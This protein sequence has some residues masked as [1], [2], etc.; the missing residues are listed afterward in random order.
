MSTI[1]LKIKCERT[2]G[3]QGGSLRWIFH[4]VMLTC[5]LLVSGTPPYAIPDNIQKMSAAITG[6][7]VNELPALDYVRKCCVVV[8]NLNNMLAS[9]ILG[10]LDNWHQIFIE[11]TTR[12]KIKFQNLVIGLVANDDFKS[13]IASLCIFLENET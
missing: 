6:S 13:L 8:H 1:R 3:R 11:G 5:K 7:E 12:K 10:K 9:C 2:I 4:V